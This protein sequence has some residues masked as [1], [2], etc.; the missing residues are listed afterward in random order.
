M[1]PA[2]LGHG[3]P[4]REW[5]LQALEV[6]D[7]G[8]GPAL[9]AAGYFTTA[10]G[11][12]DQRREW[13]GTSWSPLGAGIRAG[14]RTTPS[15]C[16]SRSRAASTQAGIST[17]SAAF[18]TSW[19]AR[20]DGLAWSAVDGG[21]G[22]SRWAGPGLAR[23]DAGNGPSLFAAG[24]FTMAGGKP[25]LNFAELIP[26]RPQLT[27]SQLGGPGSGLVVAN[28]SLIPGL[29]YF[30][31]F[32]VEPAPLGPGTGPYLGLFATDPAVL[33]AQL[34]P[35]FGVPFHFA[36]TSTTT[37]FGPYPIPSGAVIEAVCF[38]CN[39]DQ[40]GCVSVNPHFTVQ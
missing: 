25:S 40:L 1:D 21:I 12:P 34:V 5:S 18:P 37:F 35:G 13:N 16:C 8:A 28:A 17:A 26:A 9:Y 2:R 23:F 29:K 32:S 19:I 38:E 36:A 30:N 39:D 6:F 33:L 27:L 14:A 24:T 31:I 11:L 22:G 7:D 15:V 10:G 20:W 4:S 3:G